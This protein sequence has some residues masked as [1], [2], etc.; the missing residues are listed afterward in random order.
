MNVMDAIKTRK[1][2]RAYMD[3]PV[4]EAKVNQILEAGRLAPSASNRQE[5]RFVIVRELERRKNL[6][7]IAG[8]QDFIAEAPVVI[9]ACADTDGHVM[10]CGHASYLI[11]VAIALDH[12]TLAAVELGLGTCWIGDFDESKV[13]DLL[14]IP[15]K[16]RVV[17][18]M[19]LGYPADP[20]AKEKKR[21]PLNTIVK[22]EQW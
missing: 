15:E 14:G 13:K 16:I 21:F 5:W 6:A 8:R 3:R 9:V 18:L 7:Q 12:M 4:E 17:E 19:P 1:S 2:V 10:P 22:Y 11:D 20:S